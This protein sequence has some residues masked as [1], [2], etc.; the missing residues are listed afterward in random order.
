MLSNKLSMMILITGIF[1]LSACVTLPASATPAP[2]PPPLTLTSDAP[3]P[4]LESEGI[5]QNECAPYQ[6][7]ARPPINILNPSYSLGGKWHSVFCLDN[8]GFSLT[9]FVNRDQ[10]LV[11]NV[12]Y[13]DSFWATTGQKAQNAK[14]GQ[15]LIERWSKDGQYVYLRPYW[16]C[17]DGPGMLFVNVF[18]LYRM[19]LSD[20]QLEQIV[21][22]SSFIRFSADEKYLVYSSILDDATIVISVRSLDIG[23]IENFQVEKKYTTVGLF[24]WD[25]QNGNI[26]FVGA[27]NGWENSL[28]TSTAESKNGFSLLLLNLKTKQITTLINN[29]ARLLRPINENTW[30]SENVVRLSDA[31]G[32]IYEFDIQKLGTVQN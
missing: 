2:T 26:L 1:L 27:L 8:Q 19:N 7:D 25:S 16:C 13:Y 21:A 15:L 28:D 14:N 11:W 4:T 32:Q 12:S 23:H 18:A 22:N 20:G 10:N 3:R 5:G 30:V 29:D 31:N 24:S 9:R 6:V 17:L